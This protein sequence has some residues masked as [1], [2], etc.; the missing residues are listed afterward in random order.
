[1][2][3]QTPQYEYGNRMVLLVCA[4]LEGLGR[5]LLRNHP[6]LWNVCL[7]RMGQ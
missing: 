1:M 7:I 3:R 4:A 5:Y 2:K 6:S